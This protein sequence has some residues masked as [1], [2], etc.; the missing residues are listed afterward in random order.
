M[1][2]IQVFQYFFWEEWEGGGGGS[3]QGVHMGE[4]K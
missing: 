4:G 1:N 3:E 2:C